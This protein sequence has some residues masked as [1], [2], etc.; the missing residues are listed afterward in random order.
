MN[1]E[2]PDIRQKAVEACTYVNDPAVGGFLSTAIKDESE[3][4]RTAAIQLSA[5]KD[6]AIRLPVLQAGLVSEFEDVKAGA[7]TELMNTPNTEAI[8]ILITGLKDPDPDFHYTIQSILKSR[9]GQ[10][11]ETYDQAIQ[12]W[13]ANRDK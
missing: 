6:P 3:D 2:E 7:A 5:K 9:T 11:F 13:N 12:W 10:E 8:P 4:V 1:D